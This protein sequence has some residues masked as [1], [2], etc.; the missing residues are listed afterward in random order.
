M[1]FENKWIME[2]RFFNK[3]DNNLHRSSL[4]PAYFLSTLNFV[5]HCCSNTKIDRYSFLWN[6][7]KC[8]TTVLN[9]THKYH[10]GWMYVLK[11][12]VC[13]NLNLSF[14]FLTW[15]KLMLLGKSV[16]KNNFL[17][18]IIFYKSMIS[19]LFHILSA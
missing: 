12:I 10:K 5:C 14:L 7:K 19:L 15:L 8:R 13:W 1:P 9:K 17:I 16:S 2:V 3:T 6:V 11:L 4:V 18:L